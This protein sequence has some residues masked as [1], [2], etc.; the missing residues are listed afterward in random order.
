MATT[1]G[2]R[3]SAGSRSSGEVPRR[4]QPDGSERS[5]TFPADRRPL[6]PG[7]AGR[8]RRDAS[9]GCARTLL[10]SPRRSTA[11]E[12]AH[13]PPPARPATP[14]ARRPRCSR[15]LA[16]AAAWYVEQLGGARYGGP[17]DGRDGPATSSRRP[18]RWALGR[19]AVLEPADD[20]REVA[21]DAAR[22]GRWPR[23]SGG[24]WTTGSTTC[25]SS[26]AGSRCADGTRERVEVRL[27]RRPARGRDGGAA[28]LGRLG[29]A[30]RGRRAA[31]ARDRRHAGVRGRLGRRPARRDGALDHGRR[32]RTPT[33]RPSSSTRATRVSGSASG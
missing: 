24:S 4:S 26:S 8:P 15:H 22:P 31:R 14:T 17:P 5:A 25:G 20:G 27:D 6:R 33:S 29:R 30:G 7:R 32:G 23:S 2:C 3:C 11:L 12:A 13:G 19:L 16:G 28:A 1:P 18:T 10:A 21:A 9:A